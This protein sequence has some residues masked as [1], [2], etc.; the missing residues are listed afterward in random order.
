MG[1]FL[2]K[3]LF[4]LLLAAA[5]LGAAAYF[6]WDLFVRPER[7]LQAEKSAPP[8]PP[9]PDP[10]L[11]EFNKAME[12]LKGEDLLAARDAFTRFIDQNPRSSKADE[13][14]DQLGKINTDLFLSPH[15]SPEKQ[16]YVVKP[17]DV[18]NKVARITKTTPELLMRAN[19]LS[20]TMLRIGQQLYYTPADFSLLISKKDKKVTLLNHGKFFKQYP[21]TT[22][23]TSH[24]ASKKSTA[25]PPKLQGKVVEKIAWGPSGG[26][27]TFSD[28]EYSEAAFWISHT[29]AGHTLYSDPGPNSAV[30]ANKPPA[31]GIGIE[32]EAAAELGVLLSKGNPVIVEN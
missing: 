19:K 12:T 1:A 16:V 15:P 18:L 20:G 17:N 5:I 13:A 7:E 25:P 22:L 2:A 32:P 29:V 10:A 23:P 28:K 27:V 11:P 8:T 31:G 14:R 21:I 30:K 24:A 4:I 6:T 3:T 26:R 9:P